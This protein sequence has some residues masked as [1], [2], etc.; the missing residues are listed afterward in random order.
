MM[1]ILGIVFLALGGLTLFYRGLAW[2]EARRTLG[3]Q[4]MEA[5]ALAETSALPSGVLPFAASIMLVL[6]VVL[7]VLGA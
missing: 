7:V 3:E 2:M 5:E 1:Q 6:G 4:G